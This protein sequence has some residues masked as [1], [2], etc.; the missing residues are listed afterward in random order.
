VESSERLR[1]VV[2]NETRQT[3]SREHPANLSSSKA[4]VH[5]RPDIPH[6]QRPTRPVP[7]PNTPPPWLRQVQ[8]QSIEHPS[9]RLPHHQYD[10]HDL[11]LRKSQP[12]RLHE[13]RHPALGTPLRHRP[14]NPPTLNRESVDDV[15]DSGHAALAPVAPSAAG[16]LVQ[17]DIWECQDE[18]GVGGAV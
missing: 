5:H 2:S 1:F 15:W 11:R 7:H 3:S 18:D 17:S 9:G 13:R 10:A 14:P 12:A 4:P 8:H 6:P 16:G